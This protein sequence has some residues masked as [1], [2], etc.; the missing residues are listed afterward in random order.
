M[1]S[2]ITILKALSHK[3]D[4][5][6]SNVQCVYLNNL[7]NQLFHSSRKIHTNKVITFSQF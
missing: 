3:E 6:I 4:Q 7:L 1:Q 2:I 5:Y